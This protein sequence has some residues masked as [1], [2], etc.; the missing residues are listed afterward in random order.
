[1]EREM[2]GKMKKRT[3]V[4]S[5]IPFEKALSVVK[6]CQPWADPSEPEPR[7]ANDLHASVAEELCP[8]DYSKLAFFT[9][10]GSHLDRF[11]GV[12]AFFEYKTEV[13]I[14]RATLDITTNPRKEDGYKADI[15]FLVPAD[16]LDPKLD[17]EKY[18]EKVRE[19]TAMVVECLQRELKKNGY[20]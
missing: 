4:E 7:F 2:L 15:V 14:V 17:K 20:N 12:D 1:M 3:P 10:V 18:G 16:G 8:D 5:Y 19:V 13:G 6:F 9:A 11:H